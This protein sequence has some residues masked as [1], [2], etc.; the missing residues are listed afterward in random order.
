[1]SQNMSTYAFKG[2]DTQQ[3]LLEKL[4]INT[5]GRRITQPELQV[6]QIVRRETV[7]DIAEKEQVVPNSGA[8]LLDKMKLGFKS[9]AQTTA[10]DDS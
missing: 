2:G 10:G 3:K 5:Y 9:I 8:S 4:Q 6:N 1:M 7:E